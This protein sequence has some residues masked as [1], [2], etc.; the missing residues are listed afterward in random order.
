MD[1]S[2][3]LQQME[4]S[5]F[6]IIQAAAY[7]GLYSAYGAADTGYII[8]SML[9]WSEKEAIRKSYIS[10]LLESSKQTQ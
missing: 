8:Q 10:T 9:T 7:G 2:E 3:Q 5:P 6:I 1:I 4:R